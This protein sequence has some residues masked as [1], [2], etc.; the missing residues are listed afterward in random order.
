MLICLTPT[1]GAAPTI[2]DSKCSD[3]PSPLKIP[4]SPPSYKCIYYNN[5]FNLKT[6]THDM[7]TLQPPGERIQQRTLICVHQ[8]CES[9]PSVIIMWCALRCTLLGRRLNSSKIHIYSYVNLA[10]SI[11]CGLATYLVVQHQLHCNARIPRPRDFGW[12]PLVPS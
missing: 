2:S 7:V 9:E 3:A 11:K 1:S 4:P 8:C 12:L 6:H 5:N 10:L